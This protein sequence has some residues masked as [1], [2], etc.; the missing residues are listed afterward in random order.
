MHIGILIKNIQCQVRLSTKK[1]PKTGP[2]IDE[3][4]KT[5]ANKPCIFPRARGG[6]QSAAKVRA[7]TKRPPPPI[8]WIALLAIKVE[9]FEDMPES[10]E[11]NRKL[12]TANCM[13]TFRPNKSPILPYIGAATIDVRR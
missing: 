9:R 4:P 12:I 13:T 8:P 1:P 11:P 7:R 10:M 2:S 3:I 5:E 6:N